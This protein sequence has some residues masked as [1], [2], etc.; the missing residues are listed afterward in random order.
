MV[1]GFNQQF[2][3][4]QNPYLGY[5]QGFG[6]GQPQQGYPQQGQ[7]MPQNPYQAPQ[8]Q[9]QGAAQAG[10]NFGI[11]PGVVNNGQNFTAVDT[12][13]LKQDAVELSDKAVE[14]VENNSFLKTMFGIDIKNPKKTIIAF[15]LALATV[16]SVAMLGNSKLSVHKMSEFG[17]KISETLKDNNKLAGKIYQGIAGFFKKGQNRVSN[18][19]DNHSLTSDIKKAL[20]LNRVKPKS[21]FT[22]GYGQGFVSIFSLTPVDI[23]KKSLKIDPKGSN[24]INVV[25]GLKKLVGD[26]SDKFYELLTGGM[27]NGKQYTNR[28]ICKEFTEALCHNFG[29]SIKDKKSLYNLLSDLEK[30]KVT[31]AATGTIVDVTSEFTNVLMNGDKGFNPTN[32]ISSWWPVNIINKV[33]STVTGKPS[34]FGKGNLGNSLLKYNIAAGNLADTT[35]GKLVQKSILIPTESISNF[36]N[37]KSG[38]GATMLFL[39]IVGLFSRVQDA[40]KEKKVATITDDF[41]GTIGTIAIASPFA[42]AATY[43]LGSLKNTEGK[44]LVR[45]ALRAIGRFFGLGLDKIKDGKIVPPK[46]YTNKIINTFVS[47]FRKIKGIC[48][49]GFRAYLIMFAFAGLFAKPIRNTIHKIFGKPYEPEAEAAKKA[50]EEAQKALQEQLQAAMVKLQAHPEILQ[51]IESDPHAMAAIQKDPSILIQLAAAIQDT[52]VQNQ[53]QAQ[54]GFTP[55]SI[56]QNYVNNP[57]NV[58][59]PQAQPA[60]PQQYNPYAPQAPQYQP[61]QPNIINPAATNPYAPQQQAPIQPQQYAQPQVQAPAQNGI[62]EPPR[63]YIPSS[64]PFNALSGDAQGAQAAQAQGEQITNPNVQAMLSK[65]DKAEQ[66]AMRYL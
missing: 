9:Y 23:L 52:P 38:M 17:I 11:N 25:K 48:G 16:V 8:V 59:Q 7:Q 49:G 46:Q 21:D 51:V 64:K 53:Q 5:N 63:S 26:E 20:T 62:K 10:P 42:F 66:A 33:I 1:Y 30:G 60:Q 37:D 58:V 41:V 39:P 43:G 57:N 61:A 32:I 35:V 3:Q 6:Y 27:H 55:S 44:G 65:A 22:R 56:L 14:Q 31:N 24:K 50:Q 12:Q 45:S 18:F 4:Q 15:G 2:N 47:G 54:G 40:P 19:I 29:Y 13:K 34:S 28:E 36:V